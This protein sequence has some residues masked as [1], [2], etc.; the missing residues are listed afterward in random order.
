MHIPIDLWTK[1]HL[2]TDLWDSEAFVVTL[3][4]VHDCTID[5]GSSRKRRKSSSTALREAYSCVENFRRDFPNKTCQ[6]Q[7]IA[8]SAILRQSF[9]PNWQSL[10]LA[11]ASKLHEVFQTL[12]SSTTD[13]APLFQVLRAMRMHEA[14]C[15][16][17]TLSNAGTTAA[18]YHTPEPL[19]CIFG[20][21]GRPDDLRH[22]IS[23]KILWPLI[24]RFANRPFHQ[25]LACRIGL[26]APEIRNLKMLGVAF[27]IYHAVKRSHL[28]TVHAAIASRE[29]SSFPAVAEDIAIVACRDFGLR[30]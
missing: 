17:K 27:T 26:Q 30:A 8:Y 7:D 5:S 9:P 2:S 19:P 24:A 20:C 3:H 6:I 22:Y 13:L 12:D 16:V 10:F 15:A 21:R 14:M 4:K 29:F 23:C 25:V 18:R 1:G 28:Q 11:R